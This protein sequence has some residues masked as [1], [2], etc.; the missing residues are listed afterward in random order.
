MTKKSD[1]KGTST[2]R[3]FHKNKEQSEIKTN[4]SY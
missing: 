2:V 3:A 4:P 1:K